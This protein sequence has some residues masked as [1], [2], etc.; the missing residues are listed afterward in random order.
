MMI[1]NSTKISGLIMC[2]IF[3]IILIIS[4]CA[5][6]DKYTINNIDLGYELVLYSDD[7]NELLRQTY[8]KEPTI[9]KVSDSTYKIINSTGVDSNYTFFVDTKNNQISKT[10]FNLLFS[11]ANM[12]AVFENN[13]LTVTDLFD[14]KK[15]YIEI[16]R[17][18][19]KTAV[20]QSA[21][22]SVDI[23][24]DKICVKYLMGDKFEEI[25]E[26]INY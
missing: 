11:D 7:G 16:E 5:V 19:S 15:I 13:K 8:Q 21:I 12:V 9:I 17:D 18:F 20:P 10:Y 14:N 25:Y 1:L 4:G 23:F 6:K 22:L 24:K 2:V 3:C 26:E